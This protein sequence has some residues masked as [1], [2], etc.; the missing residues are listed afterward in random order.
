MVTLAT[1]IVA[2]TAQKR[3]IPIKWQRAYH[4]VLH[5]VHKTVIQTR[6]QTR[7]HRY[8]NR[9]SRVL[10]GIK[11]ITFN[12]GCG[13]TVLNALNNIMH[14][15]YLIPTSFCN[16]VLCSE[17]SGIVISYSFIPRMMGRR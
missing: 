3:V 9:V 15:M 7:N 2:S 11:L 13:L 5:D 6:H 1:K 8:T 10:P 14:S 12:E 4:A 16:S 17:C